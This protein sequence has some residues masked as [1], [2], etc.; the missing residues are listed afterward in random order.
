MMSKKQKGQ[1][2]NAWVTFARSHDLPIVV[3]G[4]DIAEGLSAEIITAPV[5]HESKPG[6]PDPYPLEDGMTPNESIDQWDA[7]IE[8][9]EFVSTTSKLICKRKT[10]DQCYEEEQ[11][12]MNAALEGYQLNSSPRE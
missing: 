6:F 3:S 12:R 7:S 11:A 4:P 1:A 10:H 9:E 8:P 2:R 5:K